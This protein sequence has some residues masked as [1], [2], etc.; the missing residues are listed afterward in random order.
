MTSLPKPVQFPQS[1]SRT[2]YRRRRTSTAVT[3]AAL[4]GAG[5]GGLALGYLVG[6][7]RRRPEVAPGGRRAPVTQSTVAVNPA[8]TP[9]GVP[10]RNDE[11]RLD[12]AIQE[13]FPGSDPISVRIE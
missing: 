8:D 10:G 4:V 2:L 13:S 7:K 6:N 1:I 12:E 3:V 9:M 5:I 11:E